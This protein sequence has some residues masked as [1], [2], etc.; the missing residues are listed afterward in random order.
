VYKTTS[1]GWDAGYVLRCH[2][3]ADC[4]GPVFECRSGTCP[5][6]SDPPTP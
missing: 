4:P 2:V 1:C 5:M 3:D 6:F